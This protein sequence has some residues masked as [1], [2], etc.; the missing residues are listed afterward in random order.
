MQSY[1][2]PLHVLHWRLWLRLHQAWHLRNS[3]LQDLD[4]VRL[5]L[6]GLA[7]NVG[8]YFLVKF[9][10]CQEFMCRSSMWWGS[11]QDSFFGDVL[12]CP[13]L[14]L[15]LLMLLAFSLISSLY[16]IGFLESSSSRVLNLANFRRTDLNGL[17]TFLSSLVQINNTRLHSTRLQ[18][19]L[20]KKIFFY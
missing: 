13:D 12:F 8:S 18:S 2:R 4:D 15:D 7:F 20:Y 5:H 16:S 1:S 9:C 6:R 14:F 3:S 19:E 10:L 11:F 17:P